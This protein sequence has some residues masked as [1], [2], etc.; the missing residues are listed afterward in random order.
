MPLEIF[1]LK[2]LNNYSIV[3]IHLVFLYN[4][5]KIKSIPPNVI[6]A[7]GK[8]LEVA[9]T[10]NPKSDINSNEH[11]DDIIFSFVNL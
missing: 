7:C 1:W 10:D 6:L 2:N 11:A 4:I 8:D 5:Y 3:A 9:L